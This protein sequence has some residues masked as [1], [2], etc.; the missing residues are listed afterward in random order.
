MCLRYPDE[1]GLTGFRVAVKT[2]EIQK[3]R[4]HEIKIGFLIR[5]MLL[6]TVTIQEW[7]YV[8]VTKPSHIRQ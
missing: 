7:N 6:L 4:R 8:L 5:L 3:D 1:V 2:N